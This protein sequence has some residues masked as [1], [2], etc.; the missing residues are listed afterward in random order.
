V[1]NGFLY[2]GVLLIALLGG[3]PHTKA[4]DAPRKPQKSASKT[5][6]DLEIEQKIQEKLAKSKLAADHFTVSV[7]RGIVTI[8]GVT[9]V[10]QHKGVMTRMAKSAGAQAVRNNIRMSATAKAKSTEA[11]AKARAK[12]RRDSKRTGTPVPRSRPAESTQL[13]RAQVLPG[14]QAAGPAH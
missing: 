11:L 13:P 9:D 2:I 12:S 3:A 5:G 1:R 7:S 8:E 4:A 10:P 6:S 14:T